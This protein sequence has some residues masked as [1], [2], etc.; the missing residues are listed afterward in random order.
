MRQRDTSRTQSFYDV[1]DAL[2]EPGCPVCR[3]RNKC[4]DSYL[5]SL[6]WES[7]SDPE[8]RE[9]M[10]RTQGFCSEHTW[11]LARPGGSVGVAIV[12]RDIL[13]NLLGTMESSSFRNVPRWS[14][15]RVREAFSSE[16][17]AAATADMVARLTPDGECAACAWVDRMEIAYLSSLLDNLEGEDGLLVSY[18]GSDGLCLPHF[19]QALA[20]TRRSAVREAMVSAQRDVWRRLT[21]QLGES[22][23]K[24]DYRFRHEPRGDEAGAWRRAIAALA[25]TR[26]QDE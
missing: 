22:I 3:L 11:R 16:I 21:A 18:R 13:Q 15:R 20:L 8:R 23:R 2:S 5:D 24:S 26:P 9:E 10:R 7:V 17:P 12:T 6:L 14:L 25:G 19:R 1:R 4:G